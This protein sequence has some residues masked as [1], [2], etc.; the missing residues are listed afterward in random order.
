MKEK[1]E[2]RENQQKENLLPWKKLTIYNHLARLT[3][4]KGEKIQITKIRN[5]RG[6]I[7]TNLMEIERLIREHYK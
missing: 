2:N 7:S 1:M 6:D 3:K 4:E 5:Q